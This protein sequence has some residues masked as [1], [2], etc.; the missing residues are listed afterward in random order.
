MSKKEPTERAI[1][2]RAARARNKANVCTTHGDK[3][4]KTAMYY[5]CGCPTTH[6]STTEMSTQ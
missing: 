2:L 3:Y 4:S 6:E 5:R 1:R